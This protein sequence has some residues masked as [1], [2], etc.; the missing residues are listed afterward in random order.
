M[1][2]L[3]PNDC[4]KFSCNPDLAIFNPL[5]NPNCLSTQVFININ[6]RRY[7]TVLTLYFLSFLLFF[8][9]MYNIREF[10]RRYNW[11]LPRREIKYSNIPCN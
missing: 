3:E 11:D 9:V 2:Y 1:R 4:E 7:S 5:V 6:L 10:N 8:S